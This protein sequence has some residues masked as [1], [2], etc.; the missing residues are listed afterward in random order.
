MK[1]T[2]RV[3]RHSQII[4][5]IVAN[6]VL[7]VLVSVN[8]L[9]RQIHKQAFSLDLSGAGHEH[10]EGLTGPRSMRSKDSI[11]STRRMEALELLIIRTEIASVQEGQVCF[12]LS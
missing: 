10:Y 6:D 8:A 12:G 7:H 9:D 3:G 11:C 5:E 1:N 2:Y 4:L